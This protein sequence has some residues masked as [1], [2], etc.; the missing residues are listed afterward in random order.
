MAFPKRLLVEGEELVMDLRPHWIALAG[1]ALATIGGMIA[2]FIVDSK[3]SNSAGSKAVWVVYLLAL[4]LYVIPK[5]IKW[6]TEHFVIT[7]DR[8]IRRQ[9]LVAKH[10][11]EIPLEHI[12]DVRF[13]QNILERMIGAGTLVVQSASEHGRE[14]FDNIRRPEEVQKTIYRVGE[15]N[16]QQMYGTGPGAAASAPST[17]TELQR[18]AELR[19][20]GVLTQEEFEAQK[21]K[22]LGT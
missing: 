22:I 21:A 13:E 3:V 16:K 15:K 18:L 20:R 8:L 14:S 4:V 2:A 10:S 19:D 7:S 12:N 5:T 11:M 1:P 9:G 6:A 17:T